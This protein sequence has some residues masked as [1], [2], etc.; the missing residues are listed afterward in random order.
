MFQLFD[1]VSCTYTYILADTQTHEAVLI[2]PVLE[3]AERDAALVDELGFRLLFAS[4]FNLVIGSFTFL[5]LHQ[6]PAVYVKCVLKMVKRNIVRKPV[7][8]ISDDELAIC[9]IS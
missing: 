9:H 8:I 3:H 5:L 2:D 4:K 6:I 7:S 1:A